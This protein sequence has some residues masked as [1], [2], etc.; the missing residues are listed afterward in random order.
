MKGGQ[1]KGSNVIY[2]KTKK[3]NQQQQQDK[4]QNNPTKNKKTGKGVGVRI[5]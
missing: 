5:G 1:I 3:V 4:K 2:P